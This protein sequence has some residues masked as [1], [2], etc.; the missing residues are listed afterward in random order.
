MVIMC[1]TFILFIGVFIDNHDEF[2]VD[3]KTRVISYGLLDRNVYV[4]VMI[5]PVWLFVLEKSWKSNMSVE[6]EYEDFDS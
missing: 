5:L 1:F 6:E 3:D 2:R 4:V